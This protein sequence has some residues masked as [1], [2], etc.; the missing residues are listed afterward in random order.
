[1]TLLLI[2]TTVAFNSFVTMQGSGVAVGGAEVDPSSSPPTASGRGT[3][4]SK[5]AATPVKLRRTSEVMR[6][7]VRSR[8]T[9]ASRKV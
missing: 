8:E 5:A 7:A 9:R 2:L 3:A 4:D 1:M 6:R